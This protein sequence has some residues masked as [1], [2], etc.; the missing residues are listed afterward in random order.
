[1]RL[2]CRMLLH[3]RGQILI[4]FN[5][6]VTYFTIEATQFVVFLIDMGAQR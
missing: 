5:G 6:L 4:W 2:N 3:M 1:M